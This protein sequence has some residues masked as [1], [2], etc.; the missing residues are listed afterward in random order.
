MKLRFGKSDWLELEP[1][2]LASRVDHGVRTFTLAADMRRAPP[3]ATAAVSRAA[4]VA[5]RVTM[6]AFDKW[7]PDFASPAERAAIGADKV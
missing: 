7:V 4:A 5:N 2:P 6:Q 3:R 1:V